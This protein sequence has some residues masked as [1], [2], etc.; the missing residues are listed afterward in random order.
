MED[1][2]C[3]SKVCYVVP[4]TDKSLE[5]SPVINFCSS[6]GEEGSNTETSKG[7]G[8]ALFSVYF[9]NAFSSK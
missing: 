6:D 9:S 2:D 1:K 3:F 8:R 7:E 5:L 4:L